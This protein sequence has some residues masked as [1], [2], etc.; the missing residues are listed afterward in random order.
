MS[1][2]AHDSKLARWT[3][4][5]MSAAI[6]LLVCGLVF[7]K[8]ELGDLRV[9]VAQLKQI[10]IIEH[11]EKMDQTAV[12]IEDIEQSLVPNLEEAKKELQKLLENT[13]AIRE[14]LQRVQHER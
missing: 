2:A 9:Q 12:V 13:H 5:L 7:I 6:V 10:V 1:T 14:M 4:K 8:L 11:K 3:V